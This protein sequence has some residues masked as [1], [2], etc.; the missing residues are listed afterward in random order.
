MLNL[1]S[2]TYR[3]STISPHLI[4]SFWRILSYFIMISP[5]SIFLWSWYT[6]LKND[7][8]GFCDKHVD[9]MIT[10]TYCQTSNISI[11]LVGN[12]LVDHSDSWSITSRCCSNNIFILGLTSS[13]NGW[14]KKTARRHRKYLS[15]GFGET[16][17]RSLTVNWYFVLIL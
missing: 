15:F 1:M 2:I 12:K 5:C 11:T 3:I 16:Y 13:Y 17:T 10:V 4:W 14:A 6:P 9:S 8:L 7:K